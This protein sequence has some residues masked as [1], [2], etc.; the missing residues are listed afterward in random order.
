MNRAGDIL[1]IN[2]GSMLIYIQLQNE[3]SI[4]YPA[5][6]IELN[7]HGRIIIMTFMARWKSLK[8]PSLLPHHPHP[9]RNIRMNFDSKKAFHIEPL[10]ES[11]YIPSPIE[12]ISIFNACHQYHDEVITPKIRTVSY[13]FSFQKAALSTCLLEIHELLFCSVLED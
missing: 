10:V 5:A 13:Q 4:Y 3:L 6:D 12:M 7:N 2:D 11:K 9:P 1:V 8:P